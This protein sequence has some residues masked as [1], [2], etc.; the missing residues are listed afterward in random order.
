VY[1]GFAPKLTADGH[2]YGITRRGF[3][4][5]G[6]RVPAAP[7]ERLR[8][9]VLA[10]MGALHLDRAL[11]VGHSIA[12]VEMSAIAQS[13]P[14]WVAGLVYLEAA[15]P[16]AF[17]DAAGPP[18]EAFLKGGPRGPARAASDLASFKS[19]QKWDAEVNGVRKPEA[20][21]R[22]TWESSPEGRPTKERV[23][24]GGPMFGAI[25]TSGPR[26]ATIPVPALVIFAIPHRPERWMD[27]SRDPAVRQ[28]ARAY[29]AAIDAA[30]ERQA[31]ALEAAVPSARVVRIPGA[32][33]IFLSNEGDVLRETRAFLVRVKPPSS[34]SRRV[35]GSRA[36]DRGRPG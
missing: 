12:G 15:Y 36:P 2:V 19:L 7:A 22:Q 28:A 8:D 23:F 24:P 33:H 11:L 31:K 35:S 27:K 1:D 34:R 9:D 20:E 25:L 13:A 4:A 17:R 5:S 32:H 10:V 14:D 26:Y 21:L 16:Y 6:F 3:G 30:T 29:F 18:M